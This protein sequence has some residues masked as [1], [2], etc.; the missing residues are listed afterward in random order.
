MNDSLP[1]NQIIQGDC[2]Q[3]MAGLPDRCV[4]LVFADPPYNLQ[5]NGALLRPN[6]TVVDAVTDTW[7]QFTGFLEY[8]D[9]TRAWLKEVRR[10]MK[11]DATLWVSGT[12]HNIFRVGTI[13]LD[14]GFWILN[15]ITWYKPNAMP[16]FRG[17][18]LK[19]DVE[20]VIW[21]KVTE[22][23]RY[24][25]NHHLMKMF[26]EGK[27]LGS[28]WEIPVCGGPERL[29]DAGGR[30]LHSTQ[31][32]EELL[33]RIILASSQPGAVV[34]DPFSG[35]GTTAAVAHMYH[36]DFIG[37]EREPAYVEASRHRLDGV[38]P[39]LPTDPLVTAPSREKPP[40][41]RFETLVERGFL[42]PGDLLTLDRPKTV[43]VITDE[44]LIRVGDDVGSIHQMG[45]KLKNSPSCNGWMHWFYHDAENDQR[46]VI[47]AFRY[48]FAGQFP[49]EAE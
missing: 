18:R 25:F 2:L 8:D 48:L 21:A 11:R 31:K 47:D 36:R 41:V 40:R 28:V 22:K 38:T 10:L 46:T 4:D 13:L 34:L 37:I 39:L 24:T 20:Y 1:L 32:P 7:D 26:N 43:G 5:L 15:T 45:A 12:Y 9:F 42:S 29:K 16:N 6:L 44:G 27:Q 35:T 3:V 17:S 33:R 49:E 19:N 23:S 30:K 14:L